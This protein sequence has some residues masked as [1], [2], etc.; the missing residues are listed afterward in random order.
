M[1]KKVLAC[2][3]CVC[4]ALS[5][6]CGSS[7][8]AKSTETEEAKTSD[9]ARQE[10]LDNFNLDGTLPIV[11][12]PSKM[13]PIKIAVVIGAESTVPTKDKEMT[14]KIMEET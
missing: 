4:I 12:D 8:S 9:A 1:K 10:E 11:K 14:K 2:I 13:E 7:T 3:L 5:T 6:G